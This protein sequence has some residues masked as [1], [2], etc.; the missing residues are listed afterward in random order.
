MRRA[1]L[2]LLDELG[3][4]NQIAEQDLHLDRV[5]TGGE[6]GV[7]LLLDD[8]H[9]LPDRAIVRHAGEDRAVGPQIVAPR[10]AQELVDRQAELLARKIV[11]RDVDR[12]Q[13]VDA[14][15]PPAGKDRAFVE[16]L[17]ERY[18]LHRIGAD[19]HLGGVAAPQV[20][21]RH[22]Q[23]RLDGMGGRVAF[24]DPAQAVR[25]GQADDDRLG[26]AVQV[27]GLGVAIGERDD[28]D[29]RDGSHGITPSLEWRAPPCRAERPRPGGGRTQAGPLPK[30]REQ[31][32]ANLRARSSR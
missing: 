8:R 6:S 31:S 14:K 26:R 3:V 25:V 5:E 19:Q 21:G 4:A 18:R 1:D 15:T 27:L 23:E 28:V 29:R 9:Q 10:A 22:L 13:R 16:L 11:E 12:R 20:L 30:E 7:E 2:D 32:G 24:A 17:P